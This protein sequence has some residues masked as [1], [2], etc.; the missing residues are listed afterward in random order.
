MTKTKTITY[1]AICLAIGVVLPQFFHII[2]AGPVFLP[3]HIPVI[4]AG[5]ICGMVWG[6]PVGIFTVILSSLIFGMPGFTPMGFSMIFELSAYAAFS[7]LF[8]KKIFKSINNV[9]RIYGSLISAMICGRV[10]GIIA[11]YIFF[12]IFGK[13]A[14]ILAITE[15]L[16][17]TSWPGIILQ[18][19]IIP[20]VILALQK[21]KLI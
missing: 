17:I 2:G 19:I 8:Y 10:I 21:S 15:S 9:A 13:G 20:P 11:Q 4:L 18:L 7:G 5:L 14:A 3:M 1:A 16:F 12:G 6:I